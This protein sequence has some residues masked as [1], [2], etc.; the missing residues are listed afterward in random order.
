MCLVEADLRRPRISRLLDLESEVGLTSVVIG[1][2]TWIR[3]CK[4]GE[5][6]VHVLSAGH[7]PPNPSELLSSRE[8]TKVPEQLKSKY[9]IIVADTPPVLAVTDAAVREN[10]AAPSSSSPTVVVERSPATKLEAFESLGRYP[11]LASSSTDCRRR[12]RTPSS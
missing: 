4:R 11:P 7:L 6:G 9:D 12:D 5:T 3:R 1:A 8:T 2:S 10:A